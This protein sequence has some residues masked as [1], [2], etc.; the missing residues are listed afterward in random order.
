[1]ITH[2]EHDD[3]FTEV[4]LRITY[5]LVEESTKDGVLSTL[6]LSHSVMETDWVFYSSQ[7]DIKSRK[8]QHTLRHLLLVLQ[9]WDWGWERDQKPKQEYRNLQHSNAQAAKSLKTWTGRMRRWYGFEC[10]WDVALNVWRF[11][12]PLLSSMCW[13]GCIYS[14]NH[15]YSCWSWMG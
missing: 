10:V 5:V 14:P 7:R 13:F 15:P 8:D 11:G 3:L 1:M 9:Q 2:K 12:V 4:R 6:F